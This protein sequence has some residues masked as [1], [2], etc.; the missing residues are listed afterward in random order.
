ML[1]VAVVGV[2]GISGTHIPAW[3]KRDDVQLVALCTRR[4]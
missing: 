1:K 2:G 4:V 3:Q